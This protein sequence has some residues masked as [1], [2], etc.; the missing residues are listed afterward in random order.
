MTIER[1]TQV[2]VL[3]VN[4]DSFMIN[5]VSIGNIKYDIPKPKNLGPQALPIVAKAKRVPTMKH[6][7]PGV[8]NSKAGAIVLPSHHAQL[9]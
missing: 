2:M 9:N 7:A 6:I 4:I 8:A 5:H 1:K 3:A